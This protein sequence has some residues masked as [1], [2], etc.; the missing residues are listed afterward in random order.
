MPSDRILRC[1]LAYLRGDS[2]FGRPVAAIPCCAP[3]PS[4][5]SGCT[6]P[7]HVK[8]RD[9]A[10]GK[11]PVLPWRAFT[12][13]LPTEAEWR[14]WWE[15]WAERC[16]VGCVTGAVSG[17]LLLDVD[18]HAAEADGRRTL[19]QRGLFIP[20]TPASVTPGDGVHAWHQYPASV[21]PGSLR[22]WQT[23]PDWPGLDARGDGGF[24][25]LPP[26]V[27]VNGRRYEWVAATRDLPLAEPPDWL[28]SAFGARSRPARAAGPTPADEW[29][30]RVCGPWAPGARHGTANALIGHLRE[31]GLSEAEVRAWMALWNRGA[32]TPPKDDGEVEDQVADLFARYREPEEPLP[33]PAPLP[34][35]LA[36]ID[37][38]PRW[39]RDALA[40]EEWTRR[41]GALADAMRDGT[42]PA[43]AMAWALDLWGGDKALAERAMRWALRRA[44]EGGG[45]RAG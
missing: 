6:A 11:T 26:S 10:A 28:L 41:A 30:A 24:A 2:P 17:A 22:N 44:R 27:G 39:R 16:N 34:E 3:D 29:A 4:S 8:R 36:E 45:R 15:T 21:T 31:H 40:S 23:R 37:R 12:E 35:A 32:C 43:V 20:E 9:H 19:A 42:D 5:P 25:V 38:Q 14:G 33:D 13:R 1:A 7:W 18:R